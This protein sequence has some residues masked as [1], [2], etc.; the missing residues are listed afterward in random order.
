MPIRVGLDQTNR[1]L[2]HKQHLAPDSRGQAPLP[3]ARDIGPIRATPPTLPYVSLWARIKGFRREQLDLALYEERSLVRITRMR[4]RL[5]IVPSEEFTAHHLVA[6]PLLGHGL[7]DLDDLIHEARGEEEETNLRSSDELAQRVLEI[8]STRGPHTIAELIQLIPELD[9]RIL[10]DPEH[11]ELGHSRLGTRL[12]P[13]M[14]AQGL[15]VR[16]QPCGGWRSDL[17]SYAT[18]PSW[19]PGTRSDSLSTREA[20]SRVVSA[21]VSAFGPVTVGDVF[22]WLGGYSRHQVYT[23]LMRLGSDLTRLQIS[24][25]PGDYFMLETQVPDL[26]DFRPQERCVCL[27]PPRDSYP[28]AYDDAGR[29]L[30]PSQRARVYDRVGESTGTVWLDGRIAGT[31]RSHIRDERIVARLFEPLEPHVLAQVGEEARSLGEMLDLDSLDLDVRSVGDS[32]SDEEERS[33]PA[34]ALGQV[35]H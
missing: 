11:P 3:V 35:H 12:V 23:S 32:E 19:L 16:A 1:Y 6:R 14:C 4:G 18:V 28:T 25:L 13:A 2:L 33:L 31:W 8:M 24:D 9:A 22:H 20:L 27:L 10:H 7:R 30:D 17:H 29:F 34:I 26:L 15:L 21:Y 5:Y